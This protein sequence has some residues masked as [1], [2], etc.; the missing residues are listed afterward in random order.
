MDPALFEL[1]DEFKK[2]VDKYFPYLMEIRNR[3]MLIVA[4]FI[5]SGLLGFFYYER[6]IRVILSLYR[7]EGVN[8]IFTSP[9]QYMTLAVS[10]GVSVGVIIIFPIILYQFLS[11]IKPALKKSEYRI[12][13]SLIPLSILLFVFG[14]AIGSLMMKY[15]VMLS[16]KKSIELQIGNYLDISKLLGQIVVTSALMGVAFQFPIVLTLLMRLKIVTYKMVAS[17]RMLAYAASVFFAALLPPTDILSLAALT[18]PLLILF[19]LTLI[20]NRVVFKPKRR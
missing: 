9:F 14:F 16:L 1:P 20:L 10:S 2:S 7:L 4:L 8:I 6:L 3:L 17:Q 19:E 15:V 18:A 5:A 13:L 11:F 12:I